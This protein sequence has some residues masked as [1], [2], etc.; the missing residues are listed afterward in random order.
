[1]NRLRE[2]AGMTIEQAAGAAGIST[3]HLSRIERAQVGVRVPVVKALLATYGADAETTGYLIEVAKEA[4]QRGWWHPYAGTIPE[5]YATYI[6]FEADAEQI[7]NFDASTLPGLLQTEEYARAMFQ[8]GPL[9]LPDDEITRRVEVRMQ[10]QAI[11]IRPNPPKVWI[12]LDEAV[13]RR[14]VG[15]RATF[16]EQLM[17]VVE[18]A[19]LPHVD[20]QVMPFAVGAHPGTPGSFIVLRFADV[21]DPAVVYIETLAGD[22]FPESQDDVSR[23]ILTFDRL[24]A[25]ALGPDESVALIREAAKE[26]T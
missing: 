10:R 20:I 2:A 13:I 8:R 22:L 14:P 25:L 12:V 4:S 9:G 1:M 5:G 19:S 24:R 11:L 16:A 6:G 21:A 3:S 17:K 7:W 18:L 23:A 26:I 15:G